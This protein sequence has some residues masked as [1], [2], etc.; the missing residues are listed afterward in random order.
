VIGIRRRVFS[1]GIGLLVFPTLVVQPPLPV[2]PRHL[3]SGPGE[4]QDLTELYR[5]R[6][7]LNF[8]PKN[9]IGPGSYITP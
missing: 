2:R 1:Q 5:T 6:V 7:L 3:G 9:C 4:E 8:F